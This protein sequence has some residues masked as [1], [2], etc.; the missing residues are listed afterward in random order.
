[1]KIDILYFRYWLFFWRIGLRLNLW[2]LFLYG[3][4]FLSLWLRYRCINWY[5]FLR[6]SF[7]G[8]FERRCLFF[9]GFYCRLLLVFALK[10][11]LPCSLDL[12]EIGYAF[13]IAFL[14]LFFGW[15]NRWLRLF[16]YLLFGLFWW[17]RDL[18]IFLGWWLFWSLLDNL[19]RRLHRS[20]LRRLLRWFLW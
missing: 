17:F 5:L 16:N 6:W 10:L 1:M 9:D 14:L 4:L 7:E 3:W 20:L 12:V 18:V 11:F 15:G 8:S 2:C 13:P 19:L